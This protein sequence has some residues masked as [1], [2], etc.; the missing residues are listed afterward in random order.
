[1]GPD[2]AHAINEGTKGKK[3]SMSS[4]SPM[5]MKNALSRHLLLNEKTC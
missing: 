4:S 2:T 5:N 3:V 1:M